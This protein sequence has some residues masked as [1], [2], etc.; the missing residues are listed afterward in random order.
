[1][2]ILSGV[3]LKLF[4]A[5]WINTFFIQVWLFYDIILRKK[6]S[7]IPWI[8]FQ[9]YKIWKE[10]VVCAKVMRFSGLRRLRSGFKTC[11]HT[12]RTLI[13]HD[14]PAQMNSP[15][16]TILSVPWASTSRNTHAGLQ[17]EDA[18]PV[19][20]EV[21]ELHRMLVKESSRATRASWEIRLISVM[22]FYMGWCSH[23]RKNWPQM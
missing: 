20:L 3:W 16:P 22:A 1:M 12:T 23:K 19:G 9:W 8:I 11:T 5:T 17:N 18:E 13:K 7:L 15:L 21:Q 14:M 10:S 6:F 2:S 4:L